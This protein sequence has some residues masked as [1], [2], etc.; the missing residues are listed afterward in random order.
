MVIDFDP[1]DGRAEI[2]LPERDL[3]VGDIF[4][5]FPPELLDHVRGNL[6][7]RNSLGSDAIKCRLCPLAVEFEAGDTIAQD[8]VQFGDA[9]FHHAIEA[10]QLVGGI[11]DLALQGGDARVDLDSFFGAAGKGGSENLGEA[12]GR[13][14]PPRQVVDSSMATI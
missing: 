5:H 4:A 6:S 13:E 2:D 8:I 1:V 11:D 7:R 3:T 12:F 14:Q 10:L 9:V